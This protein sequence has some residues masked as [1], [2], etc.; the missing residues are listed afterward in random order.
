MIAFVPQDHKLLA[1][2]FAQRLVLEKLSFAEAFIVCKGLSLP[3]GISP[4]SLMSHW[5]ES[6]SDRSKWNEAES[7]LLPF[8]IN[9]DLSGF[10]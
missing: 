10:Q 9:G 3:E 8:L 7:A 4:T 2:N 6:G 1:K 5:N